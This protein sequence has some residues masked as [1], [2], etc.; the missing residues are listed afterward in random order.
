MKAMF[1]NLT[2]AD[3]R[4]PSQ[5]ERRAAERRQVHALFDEIQIAIYNGDW[6]AV[7]YLMGSSR[8]PDRRLSES[9]RVDDASSTPRCSNGRSRRLQRPHGA[10]RDDS[11]GGMSMSRE[12]FD[13]APGL[14]IRG[15]QGWA[16]RA[17]WAFSLTKWGCFSETGM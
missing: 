8:S 14:Y 15:R 6:T 9:S 12:Y 11:R 3:F 1:A 2:S 10:H 17:H 4:R 16:G 13:G 7:D 5:K